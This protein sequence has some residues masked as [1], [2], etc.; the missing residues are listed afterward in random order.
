MLFRSEIIEVYADN[1]NLSKAFT[2]VRNLAKK[3]F[4]VEIPDVQTLL[5]KIPKNN[6]ETLSTNLSAVSN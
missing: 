1:I 3:L 2:V 5:S 6:G 4:K